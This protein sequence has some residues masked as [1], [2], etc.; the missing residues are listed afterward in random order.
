M[1]ATIHSARLDLISL[2]PPVIRALLAGDHG[3]AGRLLGVGWPADCE[4]HRDALE[5][6]LGQ[7]EAAPGLQ[8]W[9]MRAMVLR[10]ERVVVSH[11]GFH[12]APGHESLEDIFER[13]GGWI[14][15]EGTERTEGL[16]C[17]TVKLQDGRCPVVGSCLQTPRTENQPTTRPCVLRGL[18]GKFFLFR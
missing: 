1:T 10:E 15:Q 11:I 3:A 13:V 17:R 14:E 9:L 16:R 4:V 6:R 8:L 7:L 12:S 5:M 2:S 18:L